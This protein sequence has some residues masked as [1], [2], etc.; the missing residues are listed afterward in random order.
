MGRVG[1]K[2]TPPRWR[3]SAMDRHQRS[4][5]RLAV[6][7]ARMRSCCTARPSR[8]PMAS[9]GCS[10]MGG[11][12]SVTGGPR[13]ASRWGRNRRRRWTARPARPGCGARGGCV[14]GVVLPHGASACSGD[15]GV[16]HA[17]CLWRLHR[18][19]EAQRGT[20]CG[21]C[22]ATRTPFPMILHAPADL[23]LGEESAC[24]RPFFSACSCRPPRG[25]RGHRPGRFHGCPGAATCRL[26]GVD[27]PVAPFPQDAVRDR[28]ES[29]LRPYRQPAWE[30]HL[31]LRTSAPCWTPFSPSRRTFAGTWRRLMPMGC[32]TVV[33]PCW[34]KCSLWTIASRKGGRVSH[35]DNQD[36]VTRLVRHLQDDLSG[37]PG[38][39]A[40]QRRRAFTPAIFWSRRCSTRSLWAMRRSS[41]ATLPPGRCI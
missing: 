37:A 12:L 24:P 2:H 5:V 41:C 22:T 4:G 7:G 11:C 16:P 28:V 29:R 27:P 20:P 3:W 15:R 18:M 25:L 14:A 40:G 33:P 21:V 23:S 10:R 30:G 13:G 34:R 17:G 39:H 36:T 31:D 9:R 26:H 38:A 1:G 19:P 8:P 35:P 32:S 6:A